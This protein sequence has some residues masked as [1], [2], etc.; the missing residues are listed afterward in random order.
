MML[1]LVGAA[2]GQTSETSATL[3]DALRAECATFLEK[4]GVVGLS[5]AVLDEGDVVFQ[6]AFGWRDREAKL[7]A[8]DTTLFRLASVSKPVTA[9][10]VMQLVDA[11]RLELDVGVAKY[12]DGLEPEIGA[13]TL[14]R[15][16]SHTSGVRHYRADRKDNG[17]PFVSTRKALDLF[18]GDPLI[19]APGEKYSY[20][21][22]AF[23]LVV[24]AVESAAK[25]DFVEILR[26]NIAARGA[27][28]LDCEV[29]GSTKAARSALYEKTPLG[30][31]LRSEPREDLGWKYGGGG[32]ESTAL[33][34]AR[35]AQAVS[36]ATLVS[37][38]SR[39]TMWT[40]AK[41]SDGKSVDYGLGWGV[42]DSGRVISHTGSQQG[43]SSSLAIVREQ[44]L[45]VVV[46]S[47]TSGGEAP[48]LGKTLRAIA[49]RR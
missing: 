26:E 16:L 19:A 7:V 22:H 29:A 41:L 24:A 34:V 1:V 27:A 11:G 4:S 32:L 21:T 36:N 44:G 17:T 46:L 9:T 43:A 10:I 8:E 37:A 15:L 31:V 23:T 2:F 49:A 28:T 6:S 30:V 39:D 42:G 38:K 48:A 47:N 18:V 45:I 33:D 40:R 25:K 12:V 14:R 5:V 13:L 35:F 20:S 3:T